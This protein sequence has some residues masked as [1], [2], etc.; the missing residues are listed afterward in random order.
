MGAVTFDSGGFFFGVLV[1]R[2]DHR[3]A[4][5][6]SLGLAPSIEGAASSGRFLVVVG[7]TEVVD[8]N[9]IDLAT[10]ESLDSFLSTKFQGGLVSL[11]LVFG[12]VIFGVNTRRQPPLLWL[13]SCLLR[14]LTQPR[15]P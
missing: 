3:G 7:A 13:P 15:N 14:P 6:L 12:G 5:I 8:G 9:M 10:F 1:Q 4:I 11:I 2:R